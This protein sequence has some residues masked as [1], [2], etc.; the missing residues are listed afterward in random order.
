M[1]DLLIDI[2]SLAFFLKEL[3]KIPFLLNASFNELAVLDGLY[4]VFQYSAICFLA[5]LTVL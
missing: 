5:K 4:Q 2:F 1:F 3:I